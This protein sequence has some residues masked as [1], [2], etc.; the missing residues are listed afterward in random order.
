MLSC[1]ER[2]RS[3]RRIQRYRSMATDRRG[4]IS[5]NGGHFQAYSQRTEAQSS[6]GL[7]QHFYST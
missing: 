5:M 6:P 7:S 4:M 1:S 3:S 2:L